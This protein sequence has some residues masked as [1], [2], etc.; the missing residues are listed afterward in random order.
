MKMTS[1][2]KKLVPETLRE[3]MKPRPFP[4]EGLGLSLYATPIDLANLQTALDEEGLLAVMNR[5]LRAD[6]AAINAAAN[7]CLMN[8]DLTAWSGE[9]D[10]LPVSVMELGQLLA[11]TVSRRIFGRPLNVEALPD[12]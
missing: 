10:S 12:A 3:E 2:R 1:P 11:D 7:H 4:V 8:S 6:I 5:L 9:V